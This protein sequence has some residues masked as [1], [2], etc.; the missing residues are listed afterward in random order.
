MSSVRH[1]ARAKIAFSAM[2]AL[3]AAGCAHG[4]MM[5]SQSAGPGGGMMPS[6]RAGSSTSGFSRTAPAGEFSI[7]KSLKNQV[8]IGSTIDPKHGQ[9][10]PYGLTVAPSTSGKFT[11]GDLV[12]CNFNDRENRQGTGFTI[13]AL[14]PSPGS[15]P[16]L[17]AASARM[18]LGCNALALS[19]GDSIW[20]ASFKSNNNPIFSS[21]GK[22]AA[23]INGPP[24]YHPFGQIFAQPKS[25]S[26]AFYETNAA[27]GT[28]VR[29]NLGSKFTFDVIARGFGINRGRPGSIFAPSGLAYN[30]NGD[31]LYV[32]DGAT[33][34]VVSLSHVSKIPN[35]GV[36]VSKSGKTFSGKSASDAHLLFA[37]KPLNGPISSA[38]L[39]NGN[40]VV[41]NTGNPTGK[42]LMVELSPS[43]HVLDV[44]NVDKGAA[45]AIFG[46]VATGKNPANTKLYFN[47]DNA[48]NLQ[49]LEQ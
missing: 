38:L 43:G 44:R 1:Q 46:M 45:G 5:P 10:N 40:L 34:T 23:N 15:K 8:V 17:V 3:L 27:T 2:A 36:M 31:I 14:H 49:V 32:V 21:S 6:Q 28:V 11:A 39:F 18:L 7:L 33:N 42:N 22:F 26:P 24:F 37:G 9:L 35:N 30:P 48:N 12:V 25:G 41:G 16:K 47:D 4:G 19:P 20:A 29:I 13:V